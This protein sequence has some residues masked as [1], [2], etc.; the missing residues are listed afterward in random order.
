MHTPLSRRGFSLIELLVAIT[1]AAVVLAGVVSVVSSQQKAYYDG[2]RQRDAQGS[3][4]LALQQLEQAL[5]VAGYGMDAPL[6]LDFDRYQGTAWGTCPKELDPCPRDATDNSDEIVSYNRNARYWVPDNGMM[7]PSGNAWRIQAADVG[8]VKIRARAGQVFPMGQI[9]QA[10]CPAGTLYAYA[11]VATTVKVD[12]CGTPPCPDQ[13]VT[14]DLNPPDGAD[15]FNQ[16]DALDAAFSPAASCF[17][18]GQARLFLIERHRFHVRPV[19]VD[20]V[21]LPYLA[22]DAGVDTNGDDAIDDKD[23]VL[24]AEG[25]EIL[26]F[27]YAMTSAALATRGVTPGKPITMQPGEQGGTGTADVLTLLQFPGPIDPSVS[28]Y[29]ATSFFGYSVVPPAHAR[30]LTDHQANIRAIQIALVARSPTADTVAVGGR[31]ALPILNMEKLPD[32]IDQQGQYA[33]VRF[34]STVLLRNMIVRAAADF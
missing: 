15:P 9:V 12:T 11:T 6:A 2:Q 25:V 26:Q 30:R 31:F 4:R 10:V 5:Q 17:S 33:R 13:D 28:V 3:G 21:F 23:E 27:G 34:D 1:V 7:E 22:H 24:V 8:T 18:A 29:R 16:P 14:L 19:K 20:G 32:W